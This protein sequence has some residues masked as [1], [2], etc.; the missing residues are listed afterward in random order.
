MEGL[1]FINLGDC[2]NRWP[3][4]KVLDIVTKRR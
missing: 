3:L 2:Y 4:D 1:K